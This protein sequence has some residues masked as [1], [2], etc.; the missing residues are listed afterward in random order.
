MNFLALNVLTEFDDYLFLSLAKDP[1]SEVI[2][3]DKGEIIP[4]KLIKLEDIIKIETTT[5][6][7]ARFKIDGNKFN[8]K[9]EEE[10]SNS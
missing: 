1:I 8:A 7:L 3:K 2:E 10:D 5:S 9:E 4:G 6:W